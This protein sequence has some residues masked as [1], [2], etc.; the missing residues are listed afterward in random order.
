MEQKREKKKGKIC[1]RLRR[2][3]RALDRQT[4]RMR[5]RE[6]IKTEI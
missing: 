1:D 3:K 6:R 2:K 5:E 4:E